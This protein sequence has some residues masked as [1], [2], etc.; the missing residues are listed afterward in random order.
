M[1]KW[2]LT[3]GQRPYRLWQEVNRLIGLQNALS[4]SKLLAI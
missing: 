2:L 1:E 3:S 4:L